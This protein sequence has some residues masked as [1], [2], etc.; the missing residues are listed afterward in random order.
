MMTGT[1]PKKLGKFYS[2]TTYNIYIFYSPKLVDKKND[3]QQIIKN[4]INPFA[5]ADAYMHQYFH[6]LQWYAGSERVNVIWYKKNIIKGYHMA[7]Q[8]DQGV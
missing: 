2:G 7:A 8:I 4:E 6:C 3:K 1:E 5:T